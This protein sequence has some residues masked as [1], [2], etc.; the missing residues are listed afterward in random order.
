[1]DFKTNQTLGYA[2]ANVNSEVA[3]RLFGAFEGFQDWPKKSPKVCNVCWSS[4]QGL[5]SNIL[6]Y[7]NLAVMQLAVPEA[8]KPALFSQGSLV[9]FPVPTKT[10]GKSSA[11]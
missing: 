5:E 9:P 1:M 11:T 4:R 8:W 2:F 7:R 6:A 10:R 3:A